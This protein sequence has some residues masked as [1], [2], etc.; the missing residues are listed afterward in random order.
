MYPVVKYSTD[1]FELRQTLHH[2]TRLSHLHAKLDALDNTQAPELH[3]VWASA[4]GELDS[5]ISTLHERP[6]TRDMTHGIAWLHMTL[7]DF[8]PVLRRPSPPQEALVIF[9]YYTMVLEQLT[10]QWWLTG[11]ATR[12]TQQTYALLDD[13]HKT[14]IVPVEI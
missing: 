2:P 13:E 6:D 11:W 1:L 7:P 14:W 10:P 9:C 3:S 5:V 12:L 4:V 8:I